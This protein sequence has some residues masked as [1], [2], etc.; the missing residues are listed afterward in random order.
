M[1]FQPYRVDWLQLD[2]P[3]GGI[4]SDLEC[5]DV[6]VCESSPAY[7][8]RR[9]KESVLYGV[10]AGTLE[11]FLARQSE[12][13]RPVPRF[14]ERELRS[15]LECGVLA[16]GFLRV[17]CDACGRDRLVSDSCKGRAYAELMN[18]R[19]TVTSAEQVGAFFTGLP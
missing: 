15:F 8:P 5:L 17:H 9:P 14:V 12:R 1:M 16:N 10:V 11:T 2:M 19:S 7:Y 13:D 6:G 4:A 3:Y 18:M